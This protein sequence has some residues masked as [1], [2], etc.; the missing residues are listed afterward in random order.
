M[1][2]VFTP[3]KRSE[4][5]SKIRSKNTRPEETVR[6]WLFNNG[7]RYRKNVAA[8][9]GKPDV[10]LPKYGAVIFVHG[11]F[12]HGHA[13]CRYF[14]VPKTRTEWWLEKI[15]R[16]IEKDGKSQSALAAIGWKVIVVWECEIRRKAD[17]ESRLLQLAADLRSL[18]AGEK[19]KK[20]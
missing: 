17:A 20:K 5:M 7:F 10:V 13:G 2:D 6:K 19:G 14:V 1:A 15:N 16:N 11:C 18:V 12:W 9:P 4:V 3:E 8:L